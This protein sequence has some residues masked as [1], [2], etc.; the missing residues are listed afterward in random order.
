[1]FK[2]RYDK[3][4]M[5]LIEM[6]ISLVILSILM[7]ST[8]GMIISSNNIFVSTSQA[9]LDRLVGNSV[10]STLES[11]LKYSTSLTISATPKNDNKQQSFMVS[12]SDNDTKS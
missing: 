7:S 3:R 9:A 5:T 2:L 12:V 6:I 1:M 10:Y 8:M 4:G 11:M